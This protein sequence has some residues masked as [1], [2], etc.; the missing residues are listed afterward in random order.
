MSRGGRATGPRRW[1]PGLAWPLWALTLSGLAAALWLDHLLRQAGRPDLGIRTHE[2]TYVA[3]M[4]G[5]ATVGAVLAA[6]RPR[7]P[8]GWLMLALGLSVTADGVTD[9]SARYGLLVSPG[10]PGGRAGPRAWGYL[11][12]LAGLDR[13][14]PAAHPHRLA[15]VGALAMVGRDRGDRAVDL[16]A[17][18][19]PR[20]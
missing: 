20:G 6:R 1:A 7:H 19:R 14:H 16:A 13:V 15:A 18:N 4:V 3:A 5:M 2:L 11:R 8:V 9:S 10:G 17:G 12:P